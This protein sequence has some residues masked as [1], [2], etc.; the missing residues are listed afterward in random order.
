MFSLLDEDSLV[1]F[2]YDVL[3]GVCKILRLFHR[4]I[5]YEAQDEAAPTMTMVSLELFAMTFFIAL[6]DEAG[7]SWDALW[8][9]IFEPPTP[10]IVRWFLAMLGRE[11]ERW[12]RIERT[13]EGGDVKTWIV[14]L[15]VVLQGAGGEQPDANW[16]IVRF[17]LLNALW[18]EKGGS[19]SIG[20]RLR[21]QWSCGMSM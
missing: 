13:G 12:E 17:G 5:V 16:W 18:R 20:L 1:A 4:I 2:H 8:R 9:A 10:V 14:A 15:G 6:K 7:F 11:I 21:M 19:G 3:R